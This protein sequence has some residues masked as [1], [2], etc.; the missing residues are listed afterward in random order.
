MTAL[1]EAAK[2][3][4]GKAFLAGLAVSGAAVTILAGYIWSRTIDQLDMVN[5]NLVGV[6]VQGA[7]MSER[8]ARLDEW[9]RS[10]TARIETDLKTLQTDVRELQ[11]V[12][13]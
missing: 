2:N 13:R 9:N 3:G 8:V 5:T 1:V 7:T 12:P 4:Y 11:R 10:T 6:I